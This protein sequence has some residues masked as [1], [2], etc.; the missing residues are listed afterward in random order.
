MILQIQAENKF[1]G[2]DH[3]IISLTKI[4]FSNLPSQERRRQR[5][6]KPEEITKLNELVKSVQLHGVLQEPIVRPLKGGKF[7]LV[8]GE[9]RIRAAEIAGLKEVECIIKNLNDTEAAEI[10]LDENTKR[11]ELH[12]VDEAFS[13]RDM[14]DRLQC[15]ENEIASRTGKELK[16]VKNC[17]KLL[18]LDEKVLEYFEN[19]EITFNHAL[20]FAKYPAPDQL[21]LLNYCFNN[22][23][24][25]SQSLKPY[26]K[27]VESI[28]THHLLRLEKAPFPL[29]SVE[30]H[31]GISCLNCP[32]RTGAERELFEENFGEKDACLDR[33]CYE[34]RNESHIQ[35]KR[36]KLAVETKNVPAAKASENVNQIP[37]ITN[38]SHINTQDQAELAEKV[39][40]S[41]EYK[42]LKSLDD[43]KKAE[44]AIYGHGD[45]KGNEEII[46]KRASNCPIHWK[47]INPKSI[48]KNEKS[49]EALES[50][51]LERRN[52]K[53]E[54][55]DVN[56]G[57][58]VRRKVLGYAAKDFTAEKTIFNHP[59]SANY[60]NNLTQI[61]WKFLCE[62][63]NSNA[64]I[65][66]EILGVSKKR[67]STH[68]WDAD[69][70]GLSAD[71]KSRLLW[72]IL[73]VNINKMYEDG[74]YQSQSEIKAIAEEFKADYRHID[75]VERLQYA[76][77]KHEKH[78]KE[79]H[80]YLVK[81]EDGDPYAQIPR[82]Y[83]PDYK[84]ID[85]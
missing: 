23:G 79:F 11:S 37:L 42:T 48:P 10:Q 24:H 55:I 16:Y 40:T 47:D 54:I 18:T 81:V 63:E 35:I 49:A 29:E 25:D 7:E 53:E 69:I 14:Q 20:E 32:K 73:H 44:Y 34:K 26:R 43:C 56:V 33:A 75:A 39:L 36:E 62:K 31:P 67:L 77:E 13:Y 22:F 58:I 78:T 46:C 6:D 28:A 72:L 19:D 65:I 21:S 84:S 83:S 27:F 68:F 76:S 57:E 17:L 52:R 45:H 60:I 74:F 9:R 80:N 64:E 50:E 51:R 4:N 2:L 15:D 30:I 41:G 5:L 3:K 66:R 59:E 1:R 82:V 61:I 70:S 71:E 38:S 8:V 85:L 12:P